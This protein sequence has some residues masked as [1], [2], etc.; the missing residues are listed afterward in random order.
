V[1]YRSAISF[2]RGPAAR[3]LVWLLLLTAVSAFALGSAMHWLPTVLVGPI[4]YMAT[5]ASIILKESMQAAIVLVATFGI[6]FAKQTSVAAY[7]LDWRDSFRKYFWHGVMWGFAMLSATIALMGATHSYRLGSVAL[8]FADIL[9]YGVLWAV[10]FLL[11]GVAEELAFRGYLQYLLTTRI[12]FWPA[13]VVTCL[14]FGFAHRNNPGENLTGLANVALVGA[15]ACVALRRTGSLWFPIGWHM[16]FDWGESFF[17]SVPD[18]GAHVSGH[19]FNASV[20]GSNWLSGGSVGPEAS[21]F[22]VVT[23]LIGILLLTLAYPTVKYPLPSLED[24]R[25]RRTTL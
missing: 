8:G 23:T 9:K 17:Y 10:A 5:P 22:N 7:G 14:F 12:G 1:I 11:V 18:S 3:R 6:A 16:A 24:S 20:G 21:L 4:E 25:K 15:F 19:L 2:V 13:S